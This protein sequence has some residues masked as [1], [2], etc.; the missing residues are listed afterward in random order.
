MWLS[1]VHLAVAF[2]FNLIFKVWNY[3][4]IQKSKNTLRWVIALLMR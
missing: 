2:G 4:S 1:L 3:L